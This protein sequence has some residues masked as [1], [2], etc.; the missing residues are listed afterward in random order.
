MGVLRFKTP[1]LAVGYLQDEKASALAFRQGWFYPGDQGSI[2]DAGFLTLGGR[3]DHVLNIN[4]RR[5]DPVAIEQV[6]NAHPA[7]LESAVVGA[8]QGDGH[9]A[10]VAVVV[11]KSPVEPGELI[12]WCRERLEPLGVPRQI[13]VAASLPKNAGGKLMRAKLAQMVRLSASSTASPDKE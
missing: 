3:V 4:G 11:A 2:D 5:V 9:L 6:I 12:R 7:V 8:K 1:V 13:A 10:L